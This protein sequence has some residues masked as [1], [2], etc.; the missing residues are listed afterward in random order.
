MPVPA[1]D[2]CCAA[3]VVL[4]SSVSEG[5]WEVAAAGA[6]GEAEDV[7]STISEDGGKTPVDAGFCSSG[8]F[9]T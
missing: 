2:D 6:E 4:G 9:W 1:A 8:V 5:V 7:G 3:G